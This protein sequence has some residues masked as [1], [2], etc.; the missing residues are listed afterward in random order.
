[1]SFQLDQNIQI[2]KVER[3]TIEFSVNAHGLRGDAFQGVV[4]YRESIFL[5]ADGGEVKRVRDSEPFE[6]TPEQIDQSPELQQAIATL[7]RFLDGAD[8]IRMAG[9]Q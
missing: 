6:F 3:R 9:E 2:D 4:F 8:Q 1:M 7:Y 5:D